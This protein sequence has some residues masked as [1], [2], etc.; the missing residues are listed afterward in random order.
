LPVGGV[1]E[2]IH[3]EMFIQGAFSR[4]QVT[5]KEE[6]TFL[7]RKATVI[8]LNYKEGKLGNRQTFWI[9]NDTGIILKLVSS[10][11]DK[12]VQTIA[13]NEIKFSDKAKE[14]TFRAFNKRVR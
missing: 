9:D 14:N 6:E 12:P 4:G 11:G 13:F 5:V 2:L 8:V 1:N 7:N 10:D 3:P